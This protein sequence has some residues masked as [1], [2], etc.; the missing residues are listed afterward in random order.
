SED[1]FPTQS[2]GVQRVLQQISATDATDG[3]YLQRFFDFCSEELD[4]T[5]AE[6]GGDE[7]ALALATRR[8]TPLGRA[9]VLVTLCR[10]ERIPARLVTGFELRQQSNPQP[11][12]WVEA[13]QGHRWVP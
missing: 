4:S 3:E 11:H 5:T 7:V 1:Q 8:A 12:V 9:R 2:P 6:E 13:F 10:A